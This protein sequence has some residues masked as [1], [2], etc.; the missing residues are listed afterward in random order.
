MA[1]HELRIAPF[2]IALALT[3]ACSDDPDV[4]P[5]VDAA[6]KPDAGADAGGLDA[7]D[8]G[9][10]DARTSVQVDAQMPLA[11]SLRFQARVGTEQFSCGK[12]YSNQGSTRVTVQPRDLRMF[13][14]DLRLV[15]RAG[16]EVPVRLD[17]RAPWQLPEV[18]LLDF[19][20]AT[21]LCAGT[22]Q[23][24]TVL[25]GVVPPGDYV[26]IAFKNGVPESLSH[27]DPSMQTPPLGPSSL[28]WSW[29][30]GYK[31]LVAEVQQP[32]VTDGGIGYG[33]FHLG[34]TACSGDPVSDAGVACARSNRSD[35]HLSPFDPNLDQVVIDVGGLFAN[36][37]LSRVNSCHS[38]QAECAE[39]FSRIGIAFDAGTP[40][41]EQHVY[42]VGR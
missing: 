13:V 29:L 26:G 31:F 19:E 23:T 11:I 4:D 21:G 8:A 20:D 15:T 35:V 42:S 32:T 1:F 12:D 5:G 38:G 18:G 10:L 34:S 28:S 14:Q 39:F 37:D 24:N 25:T 3:A 17:M 30:L 22:T 33:I 40:V 9:A 7:G 27:A 41:S 36:T 16:I 6:S 2:V